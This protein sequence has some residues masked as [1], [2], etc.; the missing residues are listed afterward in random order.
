MARAAPQI[1]GTCPLSCLQPDTIPGASLG[2]AR[3]P[4]E[5]TYAESVAPPA[6]EDL[7]AMTSAVGEVLRSEGQPDAEVSVHLADDP[8][9]HDL[10]RRYRGVDRPTDVL[11]FPMEEDG[12]LGDVVISMDRV[13]EQAAAFGHGEQRE[14]CYLAVHGTLHLLGYDDGEAVGEADM[15]A[16]AERVLGRLGIGR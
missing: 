1:P 11:S 7:R 10:N 15:A 3:V 14:L 2:G 4:A 9:L 12:A 13:R 16:R 8:L 5:I 6:E